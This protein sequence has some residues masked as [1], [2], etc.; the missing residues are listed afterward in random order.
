MASYPNAIPSF[1]NPT[2]SNKLGGST[3]THSN[4]HININDEV[5]AIATELGTDPAGN[6]S[7]VVARLNAISSTDSYWVDDGSGNISYGALGSVTIDDD[8]ANGICLYVNNDGTN[9]GLYISQDGVLAT[10]SHGLYVYSNA[11]QVNANGELFYVK[12]NNAS[13][14]IAAAAIANVGTGHGLQISQSGVLAG[15]KSALDVYS[16][17]VN[18]NADSALIKIDQDNASST[19]PCLEMKNDG[20]GTTLEIDSNGTGAGIALYTESVSYGVYHQHGGT[21]NGYY[22]LQNGTLGGGYNA[23][24]IADGAGQGVPLLGITGHASTTNYAA[25]ATLTGAGGGLGAS[26]TTTALAGG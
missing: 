14:T 10:D 13:S 24:H 6:F 11:A 3:V 21:G 18:V 7:T 26:H 23:L 2:S 19:E 5:L 12:Q 4:Q 25:L 20:N 17:A 8:T 22:L 1:T 16:N 9:H 15:G